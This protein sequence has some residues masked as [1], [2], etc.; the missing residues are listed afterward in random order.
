MKNKKVLFNFIIILI[1]FL[2]AFLL[3]Q[4][5]LIFWK[6]LSPT[7]WW[8]SSVWTI[9]IFFFQLFL[10]FW[11]FYSFLI[12][13]FDF[14]KQVKIHLFLSIVVLFL[15]FY[16]YFKN[17]NLILPNVDNLAY[18]FKLPEKNLLFLLT[19]SIW[20]PYFFLS[21][22]SSLFQ[23]W[24]YKIY[25]KEPFYLYKISNLSSIIALLSYPIIEI[26][27][28]IKLQWN[29]WGSIFIIFILSKLIFFILL[30]L[31]KFNDKKSSL[32]SVKLKFKQIIFKKD[33]PKIR[34]IS[35]WI[36]YSAIP[37]IIMLSIW[38][39]ISMEIASIPFLWMC[40]LT[41]YLLTFI[42]WFS[43][44]I[45]NRKRTLLFSLLIITS[46]IIFSLMWS[47]SIILYLL[48]LFFISFT[49][50]SELY[51]I[52]P[53]PIYTTQYYLIISLGGIIWWFIVNI[54]SP[55]IFNDLYEFYIAIFIFLL[56]IIR[57]SILEFKI[58]KKSIFTIKILVV[59]IPILW[60]FCFL[61][62]LR[63]QKSWLFYR[64]FYWIVKIK[65]ITVFDDKKPD[66]PILVKYLVYAKTI[67]WLQIFDKDYINKATTY[68]WEHSW[69]WVLFNNE[70]KEKRNIWIIWLWIGILS[71]YGKKWDNIT[72][73]EIN[74]KVIQIAKNNF[75]Y[76][77]NSKAHI[78]LK[79]WDWRILVKDELESWL[80]NDLDIFI[81]DAFSWDSIPVHLLT[82]EAFSLYDKRLKKDWFI[83]FHISNKY[84]DLLPIV[85]SLWNEFWYKVLQ[86][87]SRKEDL[88]EYE[89]VSNW[90][91]LSKDK[92]SLMLLK[93][94]S[95]V[96]KIIKKHYSKY[97]NWTDDYNNI[98]FWIFKKITNL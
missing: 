69:I 55:L 72:F 88:G 59:L 56:F 18:I 3:F 91:I 75:D 45:Y 96:W 52:R 77:K 21:T 27:F 80:K 46:Y 78:N 93:D 5:Q 97:Y 98:I 53:K 89:K 23:N 86:V 13:K 41:I 51:L 28:N 36:F 68:F 26:F 67:H 63:F 70:R 10:F 29:I 39:K 74:P 60:I 32:K 58:S 8:S 92:K 87:F 66:V 47:F 15:I 42:L 79:I 9:S 20:L 1:I 40:I 65:D 14:K 61:N 85:T 50:H 31:N 44:K 71:S 22:T 81:V 7:F 73:Y 84:I 90:L 95:K 6:F 43:D 17:S 4:I 34:D 33:K 82:K 19:V 38:I 62:E 24:Y 64:N 57:L 12:S 48:F 16:S 94:K 54:L 49:F 2:W 35:L 76:L 37:V 25:D 30:F 83:A 11:Y